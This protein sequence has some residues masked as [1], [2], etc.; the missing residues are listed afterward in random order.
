MEF[1][2]ADISD[3]AWDQA[4]F[5]HLAIPTK[6]KRVIQV[7]SKAFFAQD[8]SAGFDDVIKGKGRALIFLLQYVYIL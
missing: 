1:A 7:V 2:V 5:D 3:I 6:K 8:S 4:S